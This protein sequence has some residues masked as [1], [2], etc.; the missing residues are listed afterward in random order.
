M[1]SSD[2]ALVSTEWLAAHL[3]APDVRIV[4]GS[5][6]LPAQKRDPKAEYVQ[7]HIPGAVFFDID[8]IADTDSPLPHMLPSPEKFSARPKP[9]TE[10]FQEI[11]KETEALKA[12]EPPKPAPEKKVKLDITP[13]PK[14]AKKPVPKEMNVAQAT[15]PKGSA[16]SKA[17]GKSAVGQDRKRHV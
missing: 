7:K 6:F 1:C 4:D 10:V 17:Q 5:F 9:R 14:N 13:D 8:E 3:K 11:R 16:S 15:Q 2:L 12:P